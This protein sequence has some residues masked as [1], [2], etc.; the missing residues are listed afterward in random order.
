MGLGAFLDIL[1]DV[2]AV[3]GAAGIVVSVLIYFFLS[4]IINR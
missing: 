3:F 1:T 4:L 2:L